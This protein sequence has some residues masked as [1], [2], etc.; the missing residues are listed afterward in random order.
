MASQGRGGDPKT[1]G[2]WD[3]M[4]IMGWIKDWNVGARTAGEAIRG[5]RALVAWER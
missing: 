2:G 1:L 4:G 5:C 3:G